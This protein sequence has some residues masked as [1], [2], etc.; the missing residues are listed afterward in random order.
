MARSP[1]TGAIALVTGP[2]HSGKSEWAELLARRSSRA[3]TYVATARANPDDPDWQ[4]RI[5]R[6]AAR[7]PAS[8]QTQQVPVALAATVAAAEPSQCLLIDSLGSWVTN[9]LAQEPAEWQASVGALLQSLEQTPAQIVL[10]AEETGWGIVPA[11]AAGRTFRERL[12]DAIRRVGAAADASYLVA[13][14]RA[15]EFSAWG[16]PLPPPD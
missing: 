2:A 8:W 7:R 16:T 15:L 11:Y 3:V 6:H 14:G 12:G 9:L 1:T 4:A 5:A 13:G 10:V